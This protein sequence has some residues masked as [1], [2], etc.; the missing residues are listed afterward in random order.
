MHLFVSQQSLTLIL[1][2]HKGEAIDLPIPF[3]VKSDDRFLTAIAT[4]TMKVAAGLQ[5]RVIFETSVASPHLGERTKVR[6][7]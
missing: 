4:I 5:P 1:S 3:F 7:L 2:L 6:G